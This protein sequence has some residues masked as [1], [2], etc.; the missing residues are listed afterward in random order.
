MGKLLIC[1]FIVFVVSI[2]S[3]D[4][5]LIFR[6]FNA[7]ITNFLSGNQKLKVHCKSGSESTPDYFLDSNASLT[8]K[9]KAAVLPNT[10]VW[11]NLWKGPNYVQHQEFYAFMGKESFIKDTCGGRKP[12]VCFWVALDDGIYVRDNAKGTLTLI[13]FWDK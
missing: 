3:I 13:Y 8:F 11:C 7:E 10:L 4:S 5:L 1:F 12:D 2:Q 9:V 6:T